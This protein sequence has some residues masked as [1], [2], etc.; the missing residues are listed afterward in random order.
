MGECVCVNSGWP[1]YMRPCS[2]KWI[3]HL[4]MISIIFKLIAL[5]ILYAFEKQYPS[6]V[7]VM[8]FIIFTHQFI[9]WGDGDFCQWLFK[10]STFLNIFQKIN[11]EDFKIC[12]WWNL[13][14]ISLQI[15]SA[16][17]KYDD[18]DTLLHWFINKSWFCLKLNSVDH[19]LSWKIADVWRS[20]QRK[21][22]EVNCTLSLE[23]FFHCISHLN[24]FTCKRS[25]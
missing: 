12:S 14:F 24:P 9:Y 10:S 4:K 20:W 11:L 5:K 23:V 6:S 21:Q 1:L 25:Q 22:E 13:A 17:S 16:I 2:F 7:N 3:V 15:K 8:T 18:D 19:G